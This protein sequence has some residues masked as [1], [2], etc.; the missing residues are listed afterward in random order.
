MDNETREKLF[1]LA[2]NN[3]RITWQM[4]TEEEDRLY[5]VIE[6]SAEILNDVAGE[7]VD[8]TIPSLA[9]RLYLDLVRY[10]WNDSLE[11]FFY[12]FID[13]LNTFRIQYGANRAS[14]VDG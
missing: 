5:A 10:I 4:E 9:R 3:L 2:K 11:L 13:S 14:D 8:Y 12:N 1:D 6:E 7:N